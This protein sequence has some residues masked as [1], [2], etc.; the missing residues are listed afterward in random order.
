[1]ITRIELDGFKTFRN[2]RLELAP[3]QV[4][5][6]PNGAGKTTLFNVITGWLSKTDPSEAEKGMEQT[7]KS[8]YT[9]SQSAECG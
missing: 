6:G 9:R 3:F 4:I 1:M 7:D 2:F 5:V 8:I